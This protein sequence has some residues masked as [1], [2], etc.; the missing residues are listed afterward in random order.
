M[1]VNLHKKVGLFLQN[2]HRMNAS[3]L[4]KKTII[5]RLNIKIFLHNVKGIEVVYFT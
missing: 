2:K 1:V 4:L 5:N 3:L